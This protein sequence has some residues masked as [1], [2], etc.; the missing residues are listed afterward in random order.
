M[1][2]TLLL[3]STLIGLVALLLQI[4]VEMIRGLVMERKQARDG[5][6]AEIARGT[7]E[8]QPVKSTVTHHTARLA[9]R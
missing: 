8:A 1:Q 2:K 6:I 9:Q 7:S 4:P 5:V 3:K